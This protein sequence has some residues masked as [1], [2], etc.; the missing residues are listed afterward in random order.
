LR[1]LSACNGDNVHEG[2]A[3]GD[4]RHSVRPAPRNADASIE[5]DAYTDDAPADA[6]A[7]ADW[8]LPAD[9]FRGPV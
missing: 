5:P 4:P 9:Q 8:V 1:V 7:D 6:D 3:S 2:A